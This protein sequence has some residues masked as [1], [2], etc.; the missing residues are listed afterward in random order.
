MSERPQFPPLY[1]PFA[2]TLEIDP[3]ERCMSVAAE[4]VEA[5]TLLWSI[6]QEAP[7]RSHCA[8]LWPKR[9][10]AAVVSSAAPKV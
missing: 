4:G 5:G 10:S 2:V 8:W 7:A 9:C 6:G 3:F 1:R